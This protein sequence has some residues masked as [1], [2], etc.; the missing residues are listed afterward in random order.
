VARFRLGTLPGKGKRSH[1][2]PDDLLGDERGRDDQ[3]AIDEGTADRTL[4]NRVIKSI[5]EKKI[6]KQK[7]SRATS[8]LI[9]HLILP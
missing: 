6:K 5:K 2:G 1:S 8:N 7:E 3:A 9:H 4:R